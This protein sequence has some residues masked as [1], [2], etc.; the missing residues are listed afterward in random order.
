MADQELGKTVSFNHGW[1][2]LPIKV[3]SNDDLGVTLTYFTAKE[4]LKTV[5]FLETIA[6]YDLKVGRCRQ[7][8]ELMKVCE[9]CRSVISVL[10]P[11]S[12]TY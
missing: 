10:G 8:I 6:A 1:G 9:Y 2:L 5:D 3:Y 7:L 12:F 4:K 11:R